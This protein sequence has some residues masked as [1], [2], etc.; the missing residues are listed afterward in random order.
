MSLF[1]EK[2]IFINGRVVENNSKSLKE[3]DIISARGY[4]K[5]VYLG[6]LG[7][8]KKEKLRVSIDRY[9]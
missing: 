9:I 7:V 6:V 1:R 8:N 4:G 2:K 3:G 5:F